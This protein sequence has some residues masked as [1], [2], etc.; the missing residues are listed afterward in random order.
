[1]SF[2]RRMRSRWRLI[3]CG[4]FAKSADPAH[5]VQTLLKC[6]EAAIRTTATTTAV[7]G[8]PETTVNVSPAIVMVVCFIDVSHP[9]IRFG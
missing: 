2:L 4:W 3:L 7:I 6:R 8:A 1:M 5:I 9:A